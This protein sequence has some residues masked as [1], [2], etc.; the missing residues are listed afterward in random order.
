MFIWNM[1]EGLEW[2]TS[3]LESTALHVAQSIEEHEL[4]QWRADTSKVP[5]EENLTREELFSLWMD[6][7]QTSEDGM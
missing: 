2:I 4:M 1:R 3:K 7:V 5:N 6:R